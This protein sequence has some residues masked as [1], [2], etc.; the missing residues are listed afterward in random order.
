MY[1]YAIIMLLISLVFFVIGYKTRF[2]DENAVKLVELN[3]V[4]DEDKFIYLRRISHTMN[5]IGLSLS[6]SVILTLFAQGISILAIIIALGG[7]LASII[8]IFRI[9][10]LYKK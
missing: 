9:N 4:K 6:V 5:A 3:K 8:N 2:R 10:K 1:Q 7:T